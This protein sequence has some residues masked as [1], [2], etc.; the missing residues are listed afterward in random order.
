MLRS[1]LRSKR[2]RRVSYSEARTETLAMEIPTT[3]QYLIPPTIRFA[4]SVDEDARRA[5]LAS[6]RWKERDA[7]LRPVLEKSIAIRI[8]RLPV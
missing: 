2:E 8:Q 6:E 5:Q 1:V 7:I 4:R 3:G